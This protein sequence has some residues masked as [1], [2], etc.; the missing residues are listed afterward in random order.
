[1]VKQFGL[2]SYVLWIIAGVLFISLGTLIVFEWTYGL[3]AF[4]LVAI[5]AYIGY[6]IFFPPALIELRI[7][8]KGEPASAVILKAWETGKTSGSLPKI[9]LKLEIRPPERVPYQVEITHS[10]K[11]EE[12]KK[13]REGRVVPVKIDSKDPKKVAILHKAS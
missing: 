9:G 7:L 10:V 3:A 1:M 12:L 2:P 5:V 6:R 4:A 13:Y 11:E 8:Q